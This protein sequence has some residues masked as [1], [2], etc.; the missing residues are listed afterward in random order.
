M[1]TVE[2]RPSFVVG[3]KVFFVKEDADA[4][5]ASSEAADRIDRFIDSRV[6][7]RGRDTYARGILVDFFEFEANPSE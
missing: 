1:L 3:D 5:L 4:Y 2:E 7:G 6:W